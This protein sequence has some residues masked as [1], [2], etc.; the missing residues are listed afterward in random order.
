MKKINQQG[1]TLVEM[2]IGITM[3]SIIFITTSSLL[4]SII[5]RNARIK[6]DEVVEQTKNDLAVEFLNYVRWADAI[7]FNASENKL[8]VSYENRDDI[9]YQLNQADKAI[10]KNGERFTSSQVVIENFSFK[11][12]LD[13]SYSLEV[14]ISLLSRPDVKQRLKVLISPRNRYQT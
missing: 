6:K 5:A 14:D 1:F 13:K 9:Y 12:Y 3:A 8:I 10:R 11:K 7:E 2:L 4:V